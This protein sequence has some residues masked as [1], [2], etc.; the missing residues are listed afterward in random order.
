[1]VLGPAEADLAGQQYKVNWNTGQPAI[2][3][4][5]FYRIQVFGGA[6]QDTPLGFAD[7][8]PVNNGNQLKNVNTGEYIGLVDGRTLP[9]RFRIERG[10]FGTN[11]ASDCAEASV[12]G[13]G[14]VVVTNTGFAGAS[15]P[16][17]WLPAPFTNVV[18]TIER[19]LAIFRRSEEPKTSKSESNGETENDPE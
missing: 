2:D 15:F 6:G 13:T 1:V 18:V 19:V 16:S 10:A 17:G 9:I 3:P 4:N 8:D 5:K 12:P 14:G 7:V 11:C